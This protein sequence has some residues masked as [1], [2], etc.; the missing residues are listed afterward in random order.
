MLR[1]IILQDSIEHWAEKSKGADKSEV[2][3]VGV[4]SV[5]YVPWNVHEFQDI[6]V[7]IARYSL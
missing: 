4:G 7:N 1:I 5:D 6:Q 3:E 2:E